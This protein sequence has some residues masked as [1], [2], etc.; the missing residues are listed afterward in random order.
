MALYGTFGSAVMARPHLRDQRVPSANTSSKSECDRCR[1][2]VLLKRSLVPSLDHNVFSSHIATAHTPS[3]RQEIEL[4]QFWHV[5]IGNFFCATT[6]GAPGEIN[7]IS[8]SLR[9]IPPKT[10]NGL[11]F[12]IIIAC[13]RFGVVVCITKLAGSVPSLFIWPRDEVKFHRAH[14]VGPTC[15]AYGSFESGLDGKKVSRSSGALF[16]HNQTYLVKDVH[17]RSSNEPQPNLMTG[18]LFR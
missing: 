10:T 11:E 6:S 1:Q 5:R 2:P 12:Q 16:M 13:E 14:S 18:F 17:D 9:R 8:S 4:N 15:M 7:P 3:C